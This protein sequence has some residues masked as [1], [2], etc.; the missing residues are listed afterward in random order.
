MPKALKVALYVRVS[1]E[2]QDLV[3]Q[4][5]VLLEE[6]RRR[7]WTVAGIYEE[8]VSGAS[9][10]RP[11]L[12]RLRH[13][14]A[15]NRFRALLFWSISR[16]GRDLL[17]TLTIARELFLERDVALVSYTQSAIDMST[18]NGKL[19]FNVFAAI[20]EAQRDELV[21]ATKRGMAARKAQ[22]LSIGRPRLP[23]DPGQVAWVV[24]HNS[25]AFAARAFGCSRST[26][27]R[28]MDSGALPVEPRKPVSVQKG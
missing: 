28:L 23:L 12:A 3:Q 6:A 7:G 5:D 16:L 13:D 15:L 27:S 24:Q 17:E 11:E 25:K 14:A 22:G 2:D 8:K 19:V 21:A 4:R 18:P 10:K 20:A 1:T 9:K 26:I